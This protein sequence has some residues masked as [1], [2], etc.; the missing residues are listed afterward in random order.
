MTFLPYSATGTIKEAQ[1]PVVRATL[2]PEEDDYQIKSLMGK[3]TQVVRF[4]QLKHCDPD[5]RFVDP[6]PPSPSAVDTPP[7]EPDS[8]LLGKTWNFWL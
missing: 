5:T 1:S 6:T 2:C 3:K 7:S 4:D 8:G